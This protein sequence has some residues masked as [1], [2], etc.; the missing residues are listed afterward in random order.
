MGRSE[1]V[2]ASRIVGRA[3]GAGGADSVECDPWR[4]REMAAD[5][6]ICLLV[7]ISYVNGWDETGRP[8]HW[9]VPS[10]NES[11]DS[12]LNIK[13]C[14]WVS[15]PLSLIPSSCKLTDITRVHFNR[16]WRG[17]SSSSVREIEKKGWLIRLAF[18]RRS[19]E[20]MPPG[21]EKQVLL[22]RS[23]DGLFTP[24]V[25]ISSLTG[26]LII[27]VSPFFLF[28]SS[29]TSQLRRRHVPSSDGYC[30]R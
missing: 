6:P 23:V 20:M 22:V 16:S 13:Y 8:L 15:T 18:F 3:T 24:F 12:A 9:Q 1:S 7:H 5:L 2:Y 17:R 19:I 26:R 29:F 25:R 30:Q 11:V 10:R 21:I 4:E 27:S 14:V 28:L